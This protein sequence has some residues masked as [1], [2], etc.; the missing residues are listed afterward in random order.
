[1]WLQSKPCDSRASHVTPEQVMWL[2]CLSW[3]HELSLTLTLHTHSHSSQKLSPQQGMMTASF[4]SSLHLWQMSS[5]GISTF[6]EVPTA[7]TLLFGWDPCTALLAK[8][9]ESVR[10]I[11]HL[12][13]EP[14]F[15][16]L[17]RCLPHEVQL[18]TNFNSTKLLLEETDTTWLDGVYQ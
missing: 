10:H 4:T 3:Y 18:D 12:N 8:T 1:M 16:P 11:S 15:R 17:P 14:W 7:S 6:F 5:G 9:E 2:Q 13:Y